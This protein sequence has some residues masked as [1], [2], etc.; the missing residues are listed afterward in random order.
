MGSF[1]GG[2]KTRRRGALGLGLRIALGL[3]GRMLNTDQYNP[4]QADRERAE[5][6]SLEAANTDLTL[7]AGT[8]RQATID[9]D[10]KKWTF[11]NQEKLGAPG[12]RILHCFNAYGKGGCDGMLQRHNLHGAQHRVHGSTKLRGREE[13]LVA[14]MSGLWRCKDHNLSHCVSKYEGVNAFGLTHRHLLSETHR[15]HYDANNHVLSESMLYLF[16]HVVT[17]DRD[18]YLIPRDG[19]PQVLTISADEFDKTYTPQ[20][21]PWLELLYKYDDTY[22]WL[23]TQAGEVSAASNFNLYHTSSY[24]CSSSTSFSPQVPPCFLELRTRRLRW[25][26]RF[27][28]AQKNMSMF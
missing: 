11:T 26:Q 9:H 6:I 7:L 24:G 4:Q 12:Q 22:K 14:L 1:D 21:R 5:D 27:A 23:I 16:M 18:R 3:H 17:F 28:S 15:R 10:T 8:R 19:Y 20:A 25:Y 2:P 13:A